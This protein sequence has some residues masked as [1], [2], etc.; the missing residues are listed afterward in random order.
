[1]LNLAEDVN[2]VGSKIDDKFEKI[3]IKYTASGGEDIVKLMKQSK[4]AVAQTTSGKMSD[5][6]DVAK[7]TK[8]KKS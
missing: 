4:G 2:K 8:Q 6:K 5:I 1:M 7:Y 3:D